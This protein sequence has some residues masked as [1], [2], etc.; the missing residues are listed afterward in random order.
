MKVYK[1]EITRSGFD[2]HVPIGASPIY[3]NRMLA[4]ARYDYETSINIG[5]VRLV[6]GEV[7]WNENNTH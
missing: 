5:K 3:T 2:W 4:M 1:I 6:E 7:H